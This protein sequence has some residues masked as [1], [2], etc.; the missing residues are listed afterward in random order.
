MLEVPGSNQ[1]KS[2][3]GAFGATILVPLTTANALDLSFTNS[4]RFKNSFPNRPRFRQAIRLECSST[5][6]VSSESEAD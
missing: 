1:Q 6:N 4:N 5:F 3:S 2:F